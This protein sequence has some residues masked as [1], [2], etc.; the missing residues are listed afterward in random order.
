MMGVLHL[1]ASRMKEGL[2]SGCRWN[3]GG[4]GLHGMQVE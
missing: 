3:E 1:D 4:G 2:L